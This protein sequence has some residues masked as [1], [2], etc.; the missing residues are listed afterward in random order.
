[1]LEIK[2]YIAYIN[3]MIKQNWKNN[4]LW[5]MSDPKLGQLRALPLVLPHTGR[6]A[7][8]IPL[9]PSGILFVLGPRQA[10]K[11][12]FLRQY[13]QKAIAE[14][15]AVE[16]IG[17]IE[18][19]SLESRHDL[20]SEMVDFCSSRNEYHLLLIDEITA[21]DKWW[22]ALKLAADEGALSNSLLICT[23]SS[24]QDLAEG[25]D[26]LPGRRGRRYPLNFELL[27]VAY[28]D[29]A[30]HLSLEEF[31][32]TGGFPWAVAEYLRSG[33]VP[34]FVYELYAAWIQGAQ[35]KRSHSAKNLDSLLHYLSNRTGTGVSVAGMARDCGIGSNHTAEAYLRVMETN[36]IVMPCHWSEPGSGVSAPR[37]NRKFYPFDPLLYHL[38]HD[39]GRSLDSAW[40]N[41]RQR[42]QDSQRLGALVESLVAS[43]L[44]RSLAMVPLRYF[45]GRKEIDFVGESAIEVKYQNR[46]SLDEFAWVS[47]VLPKDMPLTIIT[48]QTRSRK[49]AIRAVPLRDW[50]LEDR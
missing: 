47:K 20:Y 39:F 36:Y 8:S 14:G 50:L 46:V 18:A 41:A 17:L 35:V 37:K 7:R 24:S 27:P 6:L 28:A 40:L 15:L 29:V 34:P 3:S 13:V 2:H 22:L 49:G 1:M 4:P 21:L 45:Q 38:F 32:L 48:R 11:S 25:A 33:A 16:R 26:L 31:L 42:I 5:E 12:T 44:R 43:E 10:G 19:E 23:G 9:E 30:N